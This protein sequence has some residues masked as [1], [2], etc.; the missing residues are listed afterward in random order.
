M[1]RLEFWPVWAVQ[2][3]AAACSTSSGPSPTASAA[4]T[5]APTVTASSSSGPSIATSPS[6]SP[7]LLGSLMSMPSTGQILLVEQGDE[8]HL[9][10]L[11]KSGLHEVD[12]ARQHPREG[13]MGRGEIP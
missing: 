2:V 4:A 13:L 1:W 7:G 6:A 5:P 12:G 10:Y 11:D 3:V 9:V 8:H